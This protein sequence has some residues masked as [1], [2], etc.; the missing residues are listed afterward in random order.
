[1][2]FFLAF[3]SGLPGLS[4]LLFRVLVLGLLAASCTPSKQGFEHSKNNPKDSSKKNTEFE[5]E[6]ASLDSDEAS[7]SKHGR[8]S[9]PTTEASNPLAATRKTLVIESIRFRA[10]GDK[11]ELQMRCYLKSHRYAYDGKNS[12]EID[13]GVLASQVDIQPKVD[14]YGATDNRQI[15]IKANFVPGTE[16]KVSI[17]PSITT[18]YGVGLTKKIKPAVLTAPDYQPGFEFTNK[19]RYLPWAESHKLTFEARNLEKIK[20]HVDKIYPQNVVF[21][22]NQSEGNSRY[23]SEK[24]SEK[25]IMLSNIRNKT[26]GG[27]LPLQLKRDKTKGVYHIRATRHDSSYPRYDTTKVVLTNFFTVT[28]V[29]D[30]S[31]HTWVRDVRTMDPLSGVDVQIRNIANRTILSCKTNSNGY[32]HLQGILKD[33][34]EPF[35]ILYESKD[36]FTYT[37][38]SD[39]EL[40]VDPHLVGNTPYPDADNPIQAAIWSER[41]VFRPGETL[42]IG[43]SFRDRDLKAA[44]NLAVTWKV[45]DSRHREIL[46][47]VIQTDENGLA[48]LTVP[49]VASSPTGQY[50]VTAHLGD[51]AIRTYHV[52]IEE[53]MPERIE[54]SVEKAD[55]QKWASANEPIKLRTYGRYMTGQGLD[56]QTSETSC[57]LTN[58]SNN[59]RGY[60]IGK[61]TETKKNFSLKV[62]NKTVRFLQNSEANFSCD[63]SELQNQ[64][65]GLPILTVRSQV[66]ESGSGRTTKSLTKIPLIRSSSLVGLKQTKK[67]IHI[68]VQLFGRDGEKSTQNKNL[69]WM[70]FKNIGDWNYTYDSRRGSYRYERKLELIPETSFTSIALKNGSATIETQDHADWGEY[71]VRVKDPESGDLSDIRTQV[72]YSWYY[73]GNGNKPMDPD[74]L[75]LSFEDKEYKPGDTISVE[76][77]SPFDGEALVATESVS[78]H[79]ATWIQVKKGMNQVSVKVPRAT[80]G[81]YLTIAAFKASKKSLVPARVWGVKHFSVQP[82][83]KTKLNPSVKTVAEIFPGEEITI[84]VSDKPNKSVLIAVVDEGILQLTGFSSPRPLEDTFLQ[85]RKL[86]VK[87]FESMGWTMGSRMTGSKNPGGGGG[88]MAK[89][90]ST[91]AKNAHLK[92]QVAYWSG[93]KKTDSSGKVSFKFK[94]PKRFQGK[95]RYMV[96]S[97]GKEGLGAVDGNIL[98]RTPVVSDVSLPRFVR[99]GDKVEFYSQARNTKKVPQSFKT[100]ITAIPKLAVSQGSWQG[101]IAVDGKK[102]LQHSLFIDTS[103]PEVTVNVANH[104]AGQAFSYDVKLDNKP[105]TKPATHEALATA[106][107]AGGLDSLIPSHIM[108]SNLEIEV[109][110]ASAKILRAFDGLAQLVSY[111]YGCIE[112][113]TSKM[114][115]LLAASGANSILGTVKNLEK[116]VD[117]FLE[118][119][120]SRIQS[121]QSSSGGFSYWPGYGNPNIY[122]SIYATHMLVTAKQLGVKYPETVLKSALGFLEKKFVKNYSSQK[123]RIVRNTPYALYVLALAGKDVMPRLSSLIK[124]QAQTKKLWKYRKDENEYLVYATL[125]KTGATALAQ[126]WVGRRNLVVADWT[127]RTSSDPMWSPLRGASFKFAIAQQVNPGRPEHFELLNSLASKIASLKHPNTQELAWTTLGAVLYIKKAKLGKSSLSL[128]LDGK[129]IPAHANLGGIPVWRFKGE[130]LRNKKLKALSGEKLYVKFLGYETPEHAALPSSRG[131]LGKHINREVY[132][133]K[134]NLITRLELK[135]GELYFV[136]VSAHAVDVRL[137]YLA[138]TDYI[139]AGL[140]IENSALKGHSGR[141]EWMQDIS[142]LDYFE[143]RDDRIHLFSNLDLGKSLTYYY[144]VRAIARGNYIWPGL[145]VEPMYSPELQSSI[146]PLRVTIK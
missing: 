105:A 59:Y 120:F 65:H 60:S 39:L 102:S 140:E 103:S 42:K 52:R 37:K 44:S 115:P 34:D 139:P 29:S 18:N 133:K 12:C 92:V 69:E 117:K 109:A 9:I 23:V 49:T 43:S 114:F 57:Q 94:T 91:A 110:P 144:P 85:K 62:Q 73:G 116:D 74:E 33:R 11:I 137:D 84:D 101:T 41:G 99:Q 36:D 68:E 53:F 113:T 76:F 131:P 78:V 40:K 56:G 8:A 28:K 119:G 1:M 15:R 111:P 30:Q 141:R 13:S 45:E 123:T 97:S 6:K 67:G 77:E 51:Q 7:N 55:K 4:A 86:A 24:I 90:R 143:V 32:C 82:S 5:F 66:K 106:A 107:Q 127:E 22:L 63:L 125:L 138:A 35:A 71:V 26:V 81:A 136:K 135:F 75:K 124:N 89:K 21:W 132:D 61:A 25:V 146:K 27:E 31:V 121:M 112:Q 64:I 83:A 70:L 134:G 2:V 128:S 108:R 93:L 50:S 3:F 130:T 38:F 16:Y 98:V 79:E 47:K 54:L 126:E 48:E 95:L 10:Q 122:G 20:L 14:F 129:K 80:P 87:T 96:V 72:G 17:R 88:P 58:G 104:M 142:S 46:N 145:S 118:R 19:G 100:S